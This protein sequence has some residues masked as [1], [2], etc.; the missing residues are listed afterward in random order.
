M[1]KTRHFREVAQKEWIMGPVNWLA[2]L[3]A[4]LVALGVSLVWNTRLYGRARLEELGPG[5]LGQRVAPWRSLA[6]TFVLLLLSSTMIGH[7]FARV[8]TAT[9]AVK[10]WLYFM[11][12]GG[13][14]GAF[15]VPAMWIN[16]SNLRIS[17]RLALIDAGFWLMAYLSIGLTFFLMAR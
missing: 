17:A 6:L 3:V 12:T 9:L 13:L 15:V 4:A 14:A 16:Y 8:G 11:M 1:R 5:G 10:P 7:M 2:V